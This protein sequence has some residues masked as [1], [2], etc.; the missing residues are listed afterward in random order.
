[1]RIY[2]TAFRKTA[3]YRDSK[4]TWAY[5]DGAGMNVQNLQNKVHM[6]PYSS[7]WTEPVCS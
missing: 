5:Y 3:C 6:M 4:K 2:E 1:M 7:L